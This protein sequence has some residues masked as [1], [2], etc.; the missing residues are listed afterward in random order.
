MKQWMMKSL[1]VV[2]ACVFSCTA[3]ADSL[4]LDT[5]PCVDPYDFSIA[6]VGDTQVITEFAPDDLHCI[7]DWIVDNAQAKKMKFVCGLGDITNSS[8]GKEWRIAK[9]EIHKMDGVVP[10][11]LVRGNHDGTTGFLVN[12]PLKDYEEVLGGYHGKSMLNSWQ[13]FTVGNLSYLILALDYGPSDEVLAWAGQVIEEHPYH[14]VIITTHAYL[15]AD[16]SLLDA[17]TQLAPIG[18]GGYN[19]GDHIWDKLVSQY[20][21]I[22]M[23]LCGHITTPSNEIVVT[24][25]TGIKDNNVVQMLINPQAMDQNLGTCGMVAMLYFSQGGSKVQ[26]EY[27]STAKEKWYMERNQFTVTLDVVKDPAKVDYGDV[28]SDG[29]VNAND[30]LLI[31]K[32]AVGKTELTGEQVKTADVNGDKNINAKDALLVLQRAVNKI[33][34]FPVEG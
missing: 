9:E 33:Q 23:V 31:L 20:S 13:T 16:G 5:A 1:C 22:V 11:S 28:N 14:N 26:V 32:A 24:E 34:K 29:A 3:L 10:Y 2:L 27:Y 21:N 7:Y 17:S 30:A 8:T 6:V 18:T 4:W 15:D 25:A 19:N 12:F